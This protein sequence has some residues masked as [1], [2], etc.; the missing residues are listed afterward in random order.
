MANKAAMGVHMTTTKP[1]KVGLWNYWLIRDNKDNP[2][3]LVRTNHRCNLVVAGEGK[4]I[5]QHKGSQYFTKENQPDLNLA[6]TFDLIHT[7]DAS[8]PIIGEAIDQIDAHVYFKQQ[9]TKK[10]KS[11][12]VSDAQS[13]ALALLFEGSSIREAA[14]LCG[15]PK[16]TVADWKTSQVSGY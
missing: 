5:T 12:S 16:S 3:E 8:A 15:V 2:I 10:R 14:R 1:I 7:G 9:R 4:G 13:K 6:V 11:Y